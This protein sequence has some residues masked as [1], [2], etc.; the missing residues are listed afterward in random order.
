MQPVDEVFGARKL[1]PQLGIAVV[2]LCWGLLLRQPRLRER[3]PRRRRH[4]QRRGWRGSGR[5]GS[6]QR[7]SGRRWEWTVVPNHYADAVDAAA[8]CVDLGD[9]SLAG[10]SFLR[11]LLR[12]H[13]VA[14]VVRQ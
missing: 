12:L 5:R 1:L 6:G 8:G 4:R 7:G 11:Q 2:E 14:V 3:Q 9:S 13:L 10:W